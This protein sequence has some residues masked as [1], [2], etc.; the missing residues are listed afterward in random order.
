[1]KTGALKTNLLISRDREQKEEIG[2]ELKHTHTHTC[3][4]GEVSIISQSWVQEF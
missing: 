4:F 1:M 3:I 2:T